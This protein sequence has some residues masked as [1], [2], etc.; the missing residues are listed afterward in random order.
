M[1][2]SSARHGLGPCRAW[3]GGSAVGC[4]ASWPGAISAVLA[5]LASAG[6]SRRCGLCA[7]GRGPILSHRRRSCGRWACPRTT[8]RRRRVAASVPS[9][10]V[11]PR[12]VLPLRD[13]RKRRPLRRRC[14]RAA[15]A[16]DP[17]RRWHRRPCRAGATVR[18]PSGCA[19]RR[20][21]HRPT[22]GGRRRC[23]PHRPPLSHRHRPW[24]QAAPVPGAADHGCADR[25]RRRALPA[26]LSGQPMLALVHRRSGAASGR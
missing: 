16:P 18:D 19:P 26:S 23:R 22:A 3:R 15:G 6:R 25:R 14:R 17:H 5:V 10:S 11:S 9:L 13:D 7:A 12:F 2:V 4:A 8:R 1:I 24:S 21:K 20:A